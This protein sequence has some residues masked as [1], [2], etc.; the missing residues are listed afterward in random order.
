MSK[1]HQKV[2]LYIAEEQQLLREACQSFFF[3]SSEV[4]VVGTSDE[5]E[6]TS[7][8]RAVVALGSDVALI[9]VKVLQPSVV[10]EL[11]S[12]RSKCPGLGIVL[13]SASYDVKGITGLREFSKGGAIGCAFLLKHTIDTVEQ[14]TQVVTSVAQGRIIVDPAVMEGMLASADGKSSYLKD[15][16]PREL[17]V[18]SWMAKGYRNNTIAQVLCLEPKTVERHINNIYSKLGGVF[19][20]THSRVYAVTLYL[21]AT[22]QLPADDIE[23]PASV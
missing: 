18:L 11:E 12:L 23:E 7:V 10:A 8:A 21:K 17:E 9:G 14:L 19:D 3:S 22:G 5:T 13:L 1:T 20:N 16:S 4:E 6:G 15:L 2:R